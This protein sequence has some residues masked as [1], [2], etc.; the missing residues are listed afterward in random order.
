VTL[1]SSAAISSFASLPVV[2]AANDTIFQHDSSEHVVMPSSDHLTYAD[3]LKLVYK[4]IAQ[5][6][7]RKLNIVVSGIREPTAD[8]DT[9][10]SL[11][12]NICTRDLFFDVRNKIVATKR[13]GTVNGAQTRRL[14]I[15]FNSV[16]AVK[17]I[18]SRAKLLR[19]SQDGVTANSVFINKD[20][21]RE[22]SL[23]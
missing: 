3:A 10:F 6:D 19:N 14:L 17:D 16:N 2:T 21:S 13:L 9:D 8:T 5:S 7:C 20:L 1:N 11:F 18:L 15:S 22:E 23:S 4:T 12:T